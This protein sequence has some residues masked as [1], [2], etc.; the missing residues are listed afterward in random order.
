MRRQIRASST[1][2]LGILFSFACGSANDDV[3]V[4]E[5]GPYADAVCECWTLFDFGDLSFTDQKDCEE[6]VAGL[7]MGFF[8]PDPACTASVLDRELEDT[9]QLLC[10]RDSLRTAVSCLAALDSCD[11]SNEEAYAEC[12]LVESGREACGPI[13]DSITEQI[14]TNCSPG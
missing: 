10:I 12:I 8:G 11:V 13:S 4:A 1:V 9:E 7:G 6:S 2:V 5:I 14:A 3:L